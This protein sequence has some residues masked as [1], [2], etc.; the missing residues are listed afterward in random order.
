MNASY[1]FIGMCIFILGAVATAL[2]PVMFFTGSSWA[3]LLWPLA[4]IFDMWVA[5][6]V[7]KS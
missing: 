6:D 1:R 3:C 4:G 2:G 5:K 7:W